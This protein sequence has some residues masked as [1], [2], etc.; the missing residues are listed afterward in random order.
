M[1]KVR[2]QHE[3]SILDRLFN[4]GMT[5]KANKMEHGTTFAEEREEVLAEAEAHQ[6]PNTSAA[7]GLIESA[8]PVYNPATADIG[9]LSQKASIAVLGK[10]EGLIGKGGITIREAEI[11]PLDSDVTASRFMDEVS[12]NKALFSYGVDVLDRRG[13]TVPM[14]VVVSYTNEDGVDEF[15]VESPVYIGEEIENA[16]PVELKSI[17][18][19]EALDLKE[20]VTM[21][22]KQRPLAFFNAALDTME[23]VSVERPEEVAEGLREAGFNIE[24]RFLGREHGEAFGRLC[25]EV[26]LKEG[27]LSSMASTIRRCVVAGMGGKA[28]EEWFTRFEEKGAK[29]YP[30]DRSK[31]DNFST[32]S[33][34]KE[35]NTKDRDWFDRTEEKPEVSSEAKSAYGSEAK[36]MRFESLKRRKKAVTARRQAATEQRKAVPTTKEL[37]ER[38]AGKLDK[39]ANVIEKHE[40]KE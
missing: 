39:L 8:P 23:L 36:M 21:S 22:E 35:Y 2:S 19:N 16:E 12:T 20:E 4:K 28:D 11:R 14:H 6:T 37:A 15:N 40:G 7:Y 9:R 25:N 38:L 5:K 34:E 33:E 10:L 3:N 26:I 18:L 31:G 27:E 29:D 13:Q 32:R 30:A 17:A 1:R 24:S